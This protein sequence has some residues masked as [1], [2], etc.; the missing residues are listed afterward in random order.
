LLGHPVRQAILCEEHH[1]AEP[2]RPFAG[3]VIP[4]VEGKFNRHLYDG[5]VTG[6][7]KVFFPK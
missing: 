3:R 7:G 2:L 6:Y 1:L 5:R 4:I